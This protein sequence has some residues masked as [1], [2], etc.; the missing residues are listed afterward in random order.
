[1]IVKEKQT[2]KQYPVWT[3]MTGPS[4]EVVF[5]VWIVHS[6]QAQSLVDSPLIGLIINRMMFSVYK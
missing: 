1:M 3:G 5:Y 4:C 2:G 6:L